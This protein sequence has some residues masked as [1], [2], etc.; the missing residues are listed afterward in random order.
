M[1]NNSRRKRR[2]SKVGGSGCQALPIMNGGSGAAE[3]ATAVYGPPDSHHAVNN[4][5]VIAMQNPNNAV[6][7][8]RMRY[9]KGGNGILTDVA[10]PALLLYANNTFKRNKSMRSRSRKNRKSRRR[11]R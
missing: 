5:N 2:N 8:G 10:V 3:W 1:Q 7:G 11:K 9:K 6:G 4:S